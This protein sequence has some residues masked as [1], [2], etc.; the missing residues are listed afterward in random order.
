MIYIFDLYMDFAFADDTVVAIKDET[1]EVMEIPI[2]WFN[3]VRI[4]LKTVLQYTQLRPK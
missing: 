3:H 1:T 2:Q 4:K